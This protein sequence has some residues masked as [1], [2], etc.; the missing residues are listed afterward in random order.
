MIFSPP[1]VSG[2]GISGGF[3]FSLQDRTGGDLNN[4]VAVEQQFLGALNQRPEI[5]Y[6]MTSFKNNFP[7]YMVNIDAG[8]N[9]NGRHFPQ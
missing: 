5:Q 9:Q 7:Q 1:A 4:F 3:E 6:A 8:T 2:F